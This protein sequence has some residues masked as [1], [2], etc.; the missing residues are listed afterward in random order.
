[1]GFFLVGA[2]V[3][4]VILPTHHA[5]GRVPVFGRRTWR[6]LPRLERAG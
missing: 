1:M 6:G 4:R 5:W 3:G 2:V